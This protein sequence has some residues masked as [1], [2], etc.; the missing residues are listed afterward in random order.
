MLNWRER[1]TGVPSTAHQAATII[2]LWWTKQTGS[3]FRNIFLVKYMRWANYRLTLRSNFP[4]YMMKSTWVLYFFFLFTD[5]TNWNFINVCLL[6]FVKGD[7]N[8]CVPSHHLREA[9]LLS[10]S[11]EVSGDKLR[12]KLNCL[13]Q[14]DASR[15]VKDE[16]VNKWCSVVPSPNL[17][18]SPWI[19]GW[20]S[21]AQD[22]MWRV[23]H[24]FDYSVG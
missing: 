6:I 9:S 12:L 13:L 19:T 3:P 14:L 20:Y 8:T 2:S 16:W 17:T 24:M 23:I 7:T 1:Q 18:P 10:R 15:T 4:D 21:K 5:D 22:Y 11:N